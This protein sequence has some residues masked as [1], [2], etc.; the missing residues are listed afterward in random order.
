MKFTSTNLLEELSRPEFAEF[1][2]AFHERSFSRHSTIFE[3]YDEEAD[4]SEAAQLAQSHSLPDN[5]VFIVK[6]GKIRVYLAYGG[7]EF[8][9][10]VLTPGDIY[11]SHSNAFVQTL[12]DTV[13]LLT[14]TRTFSERMMA[15]PQFMFTIVRVLG[16]I[17]KN[18]FSIIDGLA[19]RDV[20]GRLARFLIEEAREGQDGLVHLDLPGELLA[21]TLGTSRQTLSTMLTDL[22][23][24]GILRKERRGLYQIIDEVRLREFIL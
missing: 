23:R 9:I 5:H 21:Q 22:T 16:G 3:R 20:S 17:L 12:E 24:S 2:S 7:K 1:L 13:I 15:V 18:A 4:W 10:A 19:L 14:D 6:S 11:V 8:T